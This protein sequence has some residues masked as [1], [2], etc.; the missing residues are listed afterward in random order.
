MQPYQGGDQGQYMQ[1]NMGGGMGPMDPSMGGPGMGGMGGPGMGGPGMGGMGGPGMGPGMADPSMM[2]GP[3]MMAGERIFPAVK[4]RGLP[5]DAAEDDIRMFLVRCCI[6]WC[7]LCCALPVLSPL[8]ESLTTYLCIRAGLRSRGHSA[9]AQGGQA[10][11][12]GVCCLVIAHADRCGSIQEPHVLGQ[13]IHRGVFAAA[14]H[15]TGA[16]C[17]LASFL[18]DQILLTPSC[19]SVVFISCCR[20]VY[21]TKKMVRMLHAV[22]NSHQ[23][24]RGSAGSISGGKTLIAAY[25]A[26]WLMRHYRITTRQLSLR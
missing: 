11:R 16:H 7:S 19:G 4:L 24:G 6:E 12:R 2:G 3:G 8:L 1:G 5:F 26:C 25:H 22:E 18:C 21:R 9:G 15:L 13:A 23:R 17:V 10:V 14:Q 20:Q